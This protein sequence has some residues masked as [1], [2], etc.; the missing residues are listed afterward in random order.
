M[1]VT[2]WCR[3]HLYIHDFTCKWLELLD[4]T[5]SL[6]CCNRKG[7]TYHSFTFLLLRRHKWPHNIPSKAPPNFDLRAAQ[8]P[9]II[10]MN[11]NTNPE[12]RMRQTE[13]RDTAVSENYRK[14]MWKPAANK[15][16]SYF[17]NH[18]RQNVAIML[19]VQKTQPWS[20]YSK[21]KCKL[22]VSVYM[23]IKSVIRSAML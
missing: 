3:S 20:I 6:Y 11:E 8:S 13:I 21:H 23:M 2:G 12:I 9:P 1:C 4:Y 17:S 16:F 15:H 22:P 10:P 14:Y 5:P 19:P 18:L 7:R